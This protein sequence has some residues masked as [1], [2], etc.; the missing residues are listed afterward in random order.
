[1][2]K[3]FPRRV[4]RFEDGVYRWKGIEDME[5]SLSTILLSMKIFAGIL[6]AMG[7][8]IIILDGV[9]GLVYLLPVAAVMFGICGLLWL[10]IKKGP[11]EITQDYEMTD[12]YIRFVGSAKST[13]TYEFRKIRSVRLLRSRH[14]IELK[15]NTG[16]AR[17]FT[18]P[19]DLFMVRDH[20]IKH[21]PQGVE[22]LYD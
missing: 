16:T 1:M 6:A 5:Q 21:A 11:G 12:D 20:I 14:A 18:D 17:V 3:E 15:K 22:V 7:V 10:L 9:H 4:T 19:E 2:N 8:F 13:Y